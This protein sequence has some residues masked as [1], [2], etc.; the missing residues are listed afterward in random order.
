MDT[1]EKDNM[2]LKELQNWTKEAWKKSDK[3]VDEKDELLFLFE[4][5]GEVAE[6]I[7][8]QNGFKKNKPIPDLEDEFGNVLLS[9]I[10]L[11]NRYNIDLEKGMKKTMKR[12][13]ERYIKRGREE[14]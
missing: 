13:E 9:L 3:K 12:V 2:R 1:G 6:A 4:E 14:K 7:R 8:I 5:I 10:T 11:A